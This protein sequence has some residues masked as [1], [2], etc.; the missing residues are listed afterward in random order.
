MTAPSPLIGPAEAAAYA[1][2]P[3]PV[4]HTRAE[5]DALLTLLTRAGSRTV[6]IGHS[7][8]SASRAA[9][10]AFA[11]T[12]RSQGGEV[13]DTV[14]WPEQAASWL[15]PARRLTAHTPDAWVI[16][17]APLGWAQMSRRLL[18]STS[19][20][21]YRTCAFASLAPLPSNPDGLRG[22]TP[23]G[24]VWEPGQN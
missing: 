1:A 7:R 12:W 21:P 16:A 18:R 22:A 9:A 17:A 8:D 11:T 23:E 4:P 13:L 24:A 15:R 3:P 5:L 14:D 6:V 10:S 20:T 2:L 19:W